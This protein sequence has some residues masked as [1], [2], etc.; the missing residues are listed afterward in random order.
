MVSATDEKIGALKVEEGDQENKQLQAQAYGS[1]DLVPFIR[2]RGE[3]KIE[4]A[5]QEVIRARR[6]FE[7][8][9]RARSDADL[10]RAVAKKLVDGL[11]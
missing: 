4:I 3:I 11:E 9:K 10:A 7:I 1:H 6:I 8:K 5:K 2:K